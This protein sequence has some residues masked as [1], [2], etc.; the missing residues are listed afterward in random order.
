MAL[1]DKRLL[2][3]ECLTIILKFKKFRAPEE[4]KEENIKIPRGSKIYAQFMEKDL[5]S[6]LNYLRNLELSWI[7]LLRLQQKETKRKN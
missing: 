2:V 7:Y 3:E 1:I 6:L 5:E 4:I